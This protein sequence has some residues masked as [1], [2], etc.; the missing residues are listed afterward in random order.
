MKKLPK[1][2]IYAILC[3]KNIKY[4]IGQATN[5]EKR[6]KYHQQMLKN[7]KHHSIKLQRCYNKYG[8]NNFIFMVLMECKP[9]ELNF[10]EKFF[11]KIFDSYE[12]G[13]NC[14]DGG[15]N[16]PKI[17]KKYKLKNLIT[18]EIVEGEN[19]TKFCEERN[20]S[21]YGGAIS[22]VINGKSLSYKGWTD[23]NKEFKSKRLHT[24]IKKE[25]IDNLGIKH[26]IYNISDF[27]K[28]HDLNI[29]NLSN[30][31]RG[32]TEQT[33][34]GWKREN[35]KPRKYQGKT[36]LIRNPA[37]KIIKINNLKDFCAENDLE[38]NGIYGV[39]CKQLKH[40][41]LWTHPDSKTEIKTELSKKQNIIKLIKDNT[42]IIISN[43][44]R[45][46][47]EFNISRSSLRYFIKSNNKFLKD[48][49]KFEDGDIYNN[50]KIIGFSFQKTTGEK[51]EELSIQEIADKYN[52]CPFQLLA[53]WK[54]R[55]KQYKD[56]IRP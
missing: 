31:L 17:T 14:T 28:K 19:L 51:I 45:F 15:E 44:R 6:K 8:K 34:N 46:C 11:I 26:E 32:A 18:G 50:I 37:G 4:Y 33:H 16:P 5:I 49:K 3:P 13:L 21:S 2:G 40:Y 9:E 7:N 36:Y 38:L 39:M 29:T 42:L 56:L 20:L 30:L 43:H 22:A 24:K 48:F 55:I 54:R 47:R 10:W 35:S 12:N 52:Y 53:L 1:I 25:V 41:R 23:A 27:A